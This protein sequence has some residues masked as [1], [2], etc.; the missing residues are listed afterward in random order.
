MFFAHFT[1][2][3]TWG[4]QRITYSVRQRKVS[5]MAPD[6]D[7]VLS[8]TPWSHE[9]HYPKVACDQKKNF[10]PP[11]AFKFFLNIVFKFPTPRAKNR[12]NAPSPPGEIKE[13]LY[14]SFFLKKPLF[15]KALAQGEKEQMTLV[16]KRRRKEESRI[17]GNRER[18]SN[19][20]RKTGSIAIIRCSCRQKKKKP[21]S[22]LDLDLKGEQIERFSGTRGFWDPKTRKKVKCQVT[23]QNLPGFLEDKTVYAVSNPQSSQVKTV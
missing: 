19:R 11:Q 15:S 6:L 13:R 5:K 20:R 4:G 9:R 1:N 22:L 12:S 2:T 17:T 16:G 10:S 23:A 18:S 7:P 21:C 14:E 8:I 3:F